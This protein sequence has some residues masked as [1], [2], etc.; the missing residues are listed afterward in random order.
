MSYILDALKKAEAERSAET[1]RPLQVPPSFSATRASSH[2]RWDRPWIW[3]GASA[4]AAALIGFAWMKPWQAAPSPK[5]AATPATP[6]TA[7]VAAQVQ[8][9]PAPQASTPPAA[10]PRHTEPAP[11]AEAKP[12]PEE[13]PV[14]AKPRRTKKTRRTHTAS[15]DTRK[16]EP[17]QVAA[18]ATENL[19][20]RKDLP[21]QIQRELPALSVG[22][23]LYAGNPADRSVV[24]NNRLLREGDQVAPG[25]VLE[26]M[27][28]DG[29]VLNY[30]G[31][32]Y[33]SGY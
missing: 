20:A 28:P 9:A 23:Y 17:V 16:P 1:L 21:Q 4:C 33:R 22:G 3:A 31:L 18:A 2:A 10:P 29:M 6:A 12:A 15:N 27:M 14:E 30:K 19:P 25:L 11:P 8:P 24:I 7:P 26:K 5:P 32:R 13:K